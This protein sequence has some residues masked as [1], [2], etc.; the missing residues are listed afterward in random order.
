MALWPATSAALPRRRV[1]LEPP[2]AYTLIPAVYIAFILS[3]C[4]TYAF[5][6]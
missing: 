2:A 6:C 3:A 1:A 5:T 4:F